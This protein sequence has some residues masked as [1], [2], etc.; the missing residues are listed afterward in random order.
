MRLLRFTYHM[1]VLLLVA[2]A[3]ASCANIGNPEGG[4]R[5]YTPPVMLRSNPAPGAVNFKGKYAG[6]VARP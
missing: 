2:M 1:A 6:G 3:V 4:P 5:D